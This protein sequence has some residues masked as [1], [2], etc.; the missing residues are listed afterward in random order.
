MML[1]RRVLVAVDLEDP[2]IVS[3]ARILPRLSPD[4][5]CRF[6]HVLGWPGLSQR[7]KPRL[8]HGQAL[9]KLQAA[10]SSCY[11]GQNAI[12][13]VLHGT[14][15]DQLLETVEQLVTGSNVAK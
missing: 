7:E 9:E 4:V 13:Q 8:T 10:V 11:G 15:I 1:F 6:V 3:Y 2:E 12:C 14:V 5:E